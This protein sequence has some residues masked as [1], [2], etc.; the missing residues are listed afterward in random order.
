MAQTT[1][2][3]LP[4][5]VLD[6]Y[7]SGARDAIS[8]AYAGATAKP[9]DSA[10]VG[11]LARTLHAWEQW[12]SAHEAYVRAQAL[13]PNAFEWLYLDAIVLRRLARHAETASRLE[14]ALRISPAYL[15][16]RVTLRSEEH[17]SELQS[18]RH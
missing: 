4:Q 3:S 12:N 5:L 8:R 18:L 2:P 6:S 17:T 16:A 15:P 7:P 9:T 1:S 14:Q 13:A 10:A 11:A